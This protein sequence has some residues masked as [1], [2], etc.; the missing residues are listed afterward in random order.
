MIKY[1]Y[2]L[3]MK[4]NKSPNINRKGILFPLLFYFMIYLINQIIIV[5]GTPRLWAVLFYFM[6]YLI[7]QIIVMKG[8]PRLWA[9]QGHPSTPLR[10]A[11]LARRNTIARY[12]L[13]PYLIILLLLLLLFFF[14]ITAS[15]CRGLRVE[16]P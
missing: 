3:N 13:I 5:K 2:K 9:M 4:Y 7:N 10:R 8:T 16:K 12:V 15:G 1:I 14:G 11:P 6:I